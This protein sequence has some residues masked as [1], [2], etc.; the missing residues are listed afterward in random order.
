MS[1]SSSQSKHQYVKN[2]NVG[3]DDDVLCVKAVR[4]DAGPKVQTR[5]FYNSAVD[6]RAVKA[7][8]A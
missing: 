5:C 1:D 6:V 8:L 2:V 7:S 4:L 3:V